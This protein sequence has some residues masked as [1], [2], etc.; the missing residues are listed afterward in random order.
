[1]IGS[2]WEYNTNVLWYMQF[3]HLSSKSSEM[4]AIAGRPLRHLHTSET[5]SHSTAKLSLSVSLA[6][7]AS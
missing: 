1:M 4:T 3:M 6:P 7:L 2:D 5:Y